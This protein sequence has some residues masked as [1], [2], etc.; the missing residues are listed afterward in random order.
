LSP[1]VSKADELADQGLSK[2]DQ[3]FP[4]VTESTDQV[5]EKVTIITSQPL[6]YYGEGKEY[7]LKVYGDEYDKRGGEKGGLITP[8]KAGVTTV[9]VVT[10]D[11]LSHFTSYLGAK[12]TQAKEVVNEKT[13]N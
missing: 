10:I 2:V 5:K 13:G 9:L 4:I 11:V 7:V 3:Q 8:V 1:Y 12:K 6:K